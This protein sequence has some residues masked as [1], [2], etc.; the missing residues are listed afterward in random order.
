M[1][2]NDVER[3]IILVHHHLSL[4]SYPMLKS[5]L[6]QNSQSAS[7]KWTYRYK[8]LPI[9]LT[10]QHHLTLKHASSS[11]QDRGSCAFATNDCIW[12][13]DSWSRCWL[14][15]LNPVVSWVSELIVPRDRTVRKVHRKGWS[16]SNHH[17][18]LWPFS[19]GGKRVSC[20]YDALRR[21]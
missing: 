4:D 13:N 12:Q 1:T 8:S 17:L 6:S 2:S 7:R 9:L 11:K 3:Y 5:L 10:K 21:C 20:R 16:R 19:H 18:Q 14:L 15:F